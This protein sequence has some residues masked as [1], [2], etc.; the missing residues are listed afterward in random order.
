M[1]LPDTRI[2]SRAASR[3]PRNAHTIVSAGEK[4]T[5]RDGSALFIPNAAELTKLRAAGERLNHRA[6]TEQR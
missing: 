1:P 4:F 2:C 3:V 5:L 6:S